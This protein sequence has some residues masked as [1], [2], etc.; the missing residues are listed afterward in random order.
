MSQMSFEQ[1]V[2][3]FIERHQLMMPD[4]RY[5]VA[6]SGGADSVALLLVLRDLGYQVEAVHCNFHL[7]DQ[8]SD[9]DEL[10]CRS[11]CEDLGVALHV[12]Q[13]ATR[14][15]AEGHHI[16]IEMA[17]RHL[18]YDYFERLRVDVDADDVVVAHHKDDS[19]E[20]VLLNLIRGTGIHGLKGID[21]RRDH[22]I[23]PLLGVG[24][25][26]IERFLKKKGAS[27]V[28]DSTNLVD[29]VVRNKIRLNI[30]PLMKSI[31]PSVADAIAV[32]AERVGMAA[33]VFDTAME[34]RVEEATVDS[35]RE[36]VL[37]YDMS[38][39]PDEYTLYFILRPYGFSAAAIDDVFKA[40]QSKRSG[41]V[42]S[43]P[44]HE[45]VF[46]GG[47]LRIRPI[48]EPFKPFK[49]PMEGCYVLSDDK[50]ISV[51]CHPVD[52]HF[53]IPKTPGCV[54]LDAQKVVFPLLLRPAQ[55]GDRFIP[56]GMRGTRL[57]SD[58]LTD[59]KCDLFEKS[60]QLLLTDAS[61]N[62]LWVVGRR[63]DDRYR[64]TPKTTSALIIQY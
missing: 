16:S 3:A 40:M 35:S 62:I 53:V 24:R 54:A 12:A 37:A 8:E 30:L 42:F 64:I 9:R 15:Y 10:F 34:K 32:T 61:D 6:L 19:V 56:F 58:F 47:Y 39:I 13:F 25:D 46:H 38:R 22:I 4:K 31:N 63:P 51:A 43:S 49:I 18:R 33:K 55:Q 36:G 41:A 5:L 23:R 14:E 44:T 28:T 48:K 57:V 27:Y 26:D 60:D 2:K 45:M 17:A 20:T 52:E 7:R 1:T 21:P 50:K 29:E 11:L 59:L